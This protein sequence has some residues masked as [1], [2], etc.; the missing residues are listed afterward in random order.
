MKQNDKDPFAGMRAV[1]PPRDL[2]GRVLSVAT[3]A[4]AE[5]RVSI[6]D[7][8]WHSTPLR[9]SWV[10]AVVLLVLAH[11]TLGRAPGSRGSPEA[12]A[13]IDELEEVF[14]LPA[15]E[16]SP[17]AESIALG[18]NRRKNRRIDS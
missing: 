17:R 12:L 18:G 13:G 5:L 2:A 8:L 10:V 6:W 11:M 7:R 15:I 16:I 14:R 4:A 9:V 1:R 3:G